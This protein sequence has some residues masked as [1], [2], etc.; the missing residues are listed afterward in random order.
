MTATSWLRHLPVTLFSAVMGLAG[1]AIAWRRADTLLAPPI[2]LT[3]VMTAVALSV[4]CALVVLYLTKLARYPRDVLQDICDP[5]TL[6]ALPSISIAFMLAAVLAEHQ[7]R[8]AA[9]ALWS[10]GACIQFGVLARAMTVWLLGRRF[11]LAQVDPVW[12]FPL[13]GNMVAAATGANYAPVELLW[14]FF[15]VGFFF[16][17]LM[18]AIVFQRLIFEPPLPDTATPMFFILIAPPAVA[19]LGYHALTGGIDTLARV[20]YY[21]ALFLAMLMLANIR[22]FLRSPFT[23]AAWSYTFPL[24]ALA[25]ATLEMYADIGTTWLRAASQIL[26]GL[27]TL[28]VCAVSARTASAI[29]RGELRASTSDYS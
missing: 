3:P 25:L 16:W 27:A 24:A 9:H 2:S 26:L 5:R 1:V 19:F 7:S 18:F 15:S 20:L 22:R 12:F 14:F 13:V 28:A 8:A 4:F 11:E 29:L 21:P 10:L 17:L 23:L 6:H